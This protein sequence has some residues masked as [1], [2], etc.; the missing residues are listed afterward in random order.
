MFLL[1]LAHPDCPRHNPESCKTVVYVRFFEFLCYGI[2]VFLMNGCFL[3]L[4]LVFLV[5][6]KRLAGKSTLK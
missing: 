5:L 2:F 3:V 4:D 1:V 6:P